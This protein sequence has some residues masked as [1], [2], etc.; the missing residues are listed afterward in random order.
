LMCAQKSWGKADAL[1]AV[2]APDASPPLDLFSL[3]LD[4]TNQSDGLA[5]AL[6]ARQRLRYPRACEP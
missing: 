4:P 1:G 5:T 6:G 3:C 2:M